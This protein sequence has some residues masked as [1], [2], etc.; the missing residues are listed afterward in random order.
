MKLPDPPPAPSPFAGPDSYEWDFNENYIQTRRK[1]L[2]PLFYGRPGSQAG[3]P[4]NQADRDTLSNTLYE[5]GVPF[6]EQIDFWGWGPYSTMYMRKVRYGYERVPVGTGA[7][8]PPPTV[9]TP[10]DLHGPVVP[11]YLLV[12]VDIADFPPHK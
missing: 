12:S 10:E 3:E 5:S 4:L 7:T 6:D 1:E 2:Q 8:N 11:G 9:V